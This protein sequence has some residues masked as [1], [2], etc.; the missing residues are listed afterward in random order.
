LPAPL[1]ILFCFSR[2]GLANKNAKILFLGLDNAGKTTLLHMLKDE[3]LSQHNPTQHPTSEELS[4]AKIK[5]RTFDLGGHEIARKVWKDYFPQVRSAANR[6]AFLSLRLQLLCTVWRHIVLEF[7]W[8][9][10]RSAALSLLPQVDAIV[11]LVD[12]FDRERFPEAKKELDSLL[13]SEDLSDVPFLILGNKIDLGR[14][15]SEDELRIQLGL[16][17]NTTGKGKV[18]L[19]GIR[20]M[21]LFMC[22]VVRRSGYG[23]GFKWLSNYIK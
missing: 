21:E 12:T 19:N 7:L 14:A 15:A 5:F 8:L 1:F 6:T 9:T 3:R 11:F 2:A 18:A 20:P 4:I 16:H 23:E 13:S 22:S 17:N 10:R